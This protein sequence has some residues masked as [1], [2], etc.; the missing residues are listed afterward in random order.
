M[1]KGNYFQTETLAAAKIINSVATIAEA[2][3]RVT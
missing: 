3:K 2:L 1:V